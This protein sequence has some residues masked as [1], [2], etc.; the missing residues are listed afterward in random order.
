MHHAQRQAKWLRYMF[1][2]KLIKTT[3]LQHKFVR[4]TKNREH[5]KEWT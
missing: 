2:K 4:G 1:W 5:G 3:P